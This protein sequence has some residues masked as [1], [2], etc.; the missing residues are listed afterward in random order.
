MVKVKNKKTIENL[1]KKSFL[2]NKNR[3]IIAII[4]IV[5][6]TILFTTIFSLF[7]TLVSSMKETELR[8][9][10]GKSQGSFK[11]LN[12]EQYENLKQHKDIKDIS[13]SVVLA[14][15]ENRELLKRQCEI[16]YANDELFTEFTF[17]KPTSGRLPQ[18]EDEIATDTIILQMLGIPQKLG[19]KLTIEYEL[20]GKI[21]KDTFKLVGFWEGDKIAPASQIWVSKE[22]ITTKLGNDLT[23]RIYAYFNLKD[24]SKG[25]LEEKILK[26]IYDSGYNKN[27]IDYGINLAYFSNKNVNS[28]VMLS[29]LG[30]ALLIVFSGYLII[31]NIFFISIYK[32][33]KFYGLLK[34]IGTTKKQINYLIR[35]QAI[36]I[37]LIGIPLGLIIGILIGKYFAPIFL[38]ST[39]ATYVKISF[40]PLIFIFSI[41]FVLITVFISIFKPCKYIAKLTPIEAIKQTENNQN[42][43]KKKKKTNKVNIF[44][45]SL[46]NALRNKSKLILVCISL[47]LGGT[48]LNFAYSLANSMSFEKY[49]KQYIAGDFM[50]TDI[51]YFSLS[52]GYS[53]NDK[54]LTNTEIDE[55][56]KANN[57]KSVEK[58]YFTHTFSKTDKNYLS[59]PQKFEKVLNYSKEDLKWLDEELKKE[60]Q[61]FHIY[62][63]DDTIFNKLEVFEGEIDLEKLKT[64][65]YILVNNYYNKFNVYDIGDTVEFKTENGDT[66]K[67]EILAIVDDLYSISVKHSHLLDSQF[68]LPSNIFLENFK[69]IEPMIAI[70]N[71][72]DKNK[73]TLDKF[74]KNYTE[75]INL[76]LAYESTENIK[77]NFEKDIN[78]FKITGLL[79]TFILSIIGI[80]NFINTILTAIISRK[81]EFAILQ[82]VGMTN[83]Q[84]KKMLIFEGI[85]YIL[86]AFIIS[87]TIGNLICYHFIKN[88][89][90][91]SPYMC[92]NYTIF[93]SI[94]LFLL[95]LIISIFTTIISQN[96]IRKNSIVERLREADN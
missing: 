39:N 93:P 81:S 88:I 78:S 57:I 64:G 36:Y 71:V 27:D 32:D 87:L 85:I 60:E 83:R 45:M 4:S 15:A 77:K 21:I 9:V 68:Y 11:R 14:I 7:F 61:I 1:A 24:I 3:N 74:L 95:F 80:L 6:T 92:L 16:R 82:S 17:T 75:N 51:N 33:I 25:N 94:L 30:I 8:Q 48:I 28:S 96:K 41:I 76:Q 46:K 62:G 49:L 86:I 67:F 91:Q 47:A 31:S 89:A 44:N 37:C 58:V 13:Y 38:Q 69:S 18:N 22:Y 40:N 29:V 63:L 70:F 59:L 73:E 20:N 52:K 56:A 54:I 53:E 72:E 79:I 34:T 43:K 2:Y 10:G 35:K 42:F 90:S 5:L 23:N 50:L 19:E 26:I 12:L 65:K 66:K 55:I 84:M